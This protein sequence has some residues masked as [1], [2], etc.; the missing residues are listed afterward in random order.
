MGNSNWFRCPRSLCSASQRLVRGLRTSALVEARILAADPI[1][2]VCGEIL[3]QRKHELVALDKTPK[4]AEL[5]DMIADYEG[6]I[7]RRFVIFPKGAPRKAGASC[8]RMRS[9]GGRLGAADDFAF[10]RSIFL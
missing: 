5:I 6:L 10:L 8:V 7:V 9:A 1:E 2:K 3:K 4:P